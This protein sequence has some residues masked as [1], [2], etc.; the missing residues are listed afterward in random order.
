MS[1]FIVRNIQRSS[2]STCTSSSF[3]LLRSCIILSIALCGMPISH[4]PF[5]VI[6]VP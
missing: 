6:V 3:I 1:A 4:Q 2:R 5:H